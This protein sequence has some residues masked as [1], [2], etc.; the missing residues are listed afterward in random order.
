MNV[1]IEQL[2]GL[3]EVVEQKDNKRSTQLKAL[4][5]IA[6]I[7]EYVEREPEIP[8]EAFHNLSNDMKLLYIAGF[9]LIIGLTAQE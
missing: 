9:L 5:K 1:L 7:Q 3:Y 2:Q 8:D 6:E 4:A